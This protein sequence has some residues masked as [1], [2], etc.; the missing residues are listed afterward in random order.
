MNILLTSAGRRSYLVDYFKEAWKGYGEVHASNSS[1][2]STA[3]F[4]ADKFVLSPEIHD[5]H[6]RDFLLEY[7]RGNRIGVIVPL[8]DVDLPVLAVFKEAFAAEGIEII[9]ASL[10]ALRI[11]NDKW[12]TFETLRDHEIRVP[13]TFL[14]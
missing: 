12:Y 10:E 3:L 13:Q 6:Y 9:V 8:F 1:I 5:E 11:C 14:S 4:H 2:Q 7:C